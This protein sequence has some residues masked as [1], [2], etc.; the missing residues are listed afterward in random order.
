MADKKLHCWADGPLTDDGCSTTCMLVRDHDGPHEWTRD[1]QIG[2]RFSSA[3]R[4]GKD[5]D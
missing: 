4:E 2:V 5:D 3:N 1:D